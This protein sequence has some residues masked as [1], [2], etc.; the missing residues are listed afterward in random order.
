MSAPWRNRIA[1]H[2]TEAPDQLL[3]NPRNWRIHP[4]EQQE[5][6]AAVLDR[7]GWVQ[8][9][10]VNRTTGYVLD[11]HARVGLAISRGEA[12]IPVVYVDLDEEEEALMLAS[13]DPLAAMA[14]T[15]EEALASLVD[16]LVT[17]GDLAEMLAELLPKPEAPPAPK[18]AY[19]QEIRSPI[20]E[21]TGPQP[22]V[23]ALLDT[24]RTDAL[25][26]E[27]EA[28]SVPADVKG[29][30]RAA[31]HRHTV[32]SFDKVAN[33]YAHATAEEQRLIE[34]SALVL[35]DAKQAI[36]RGFMTLN[37]KILEAF[38]EDYPDAR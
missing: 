32:I 16:G 31:A 11:G 33:Y 38:D 22:P 23:T 27:I 24:T 18:P 29:F 7:V 1:G 15:D 26:A 5:A 20:Y 3:A 34:A 10:I 9:V 13:L 21:P 17:E 2:G 35:L 8:D 12:A 4:K 37:E 6:L 19:I 36:E 25:L 14:V 28:S 30:L